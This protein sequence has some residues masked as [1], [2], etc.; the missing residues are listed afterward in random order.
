MRRKNRYNKDEITTIQTDQGWQYTLKVTEEILKA[1]NIIHSMSGKGR[2]IDNHTIENVFGKIKREF[3]YTRSFN[4]IEEL[5]YGLT[6]YIRT[7]NNKRPQAKLQT[8]PMNFRK[9]KAE[10]K[11]VA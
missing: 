9:K 7:W 6:R 4:N 11:N 10:H 5:E 1:N 3:I 8:S 2:C